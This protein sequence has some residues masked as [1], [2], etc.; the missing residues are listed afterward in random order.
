VPSQT[1]IDL[2]SGAGGATQGLTDAGVTVLGAIENDEIAADSYSRNHPK[3]AVDTRDIRLVDEGELRAQ[4]GLAVGELTLLKACPP[5]QGFSSLASGK[6][7]S[8]RNDLV[9][10]V[11]RFVREF[12]PRSVLLENV[13]G[14]R[15]DDRLRTLLEEISALG[16]VSAQYIVQATE[17]GVPQ[18]RRRLIVMAIRGGRVED[19]PDNVMALLPEDFD[20]SAKTAG[21]ALDRLAETA[22]AGDSLDRSRKHSSN[23]IE[24]IAAVPLNGTRF[25]LPVKHQLACHTRLSERGL[26]TATASYGRVKRDSAA[27]TMTTR[28]TTPSCGSFIHPTE[29]RGLTLREAAVLQTFPVDYQFVGNYGE[30]ERQIGNA[31]PVRLAHALGTALLTLL[32]LKDLS[33][34]A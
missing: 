4:L 16:Y 2:F 10:D 34:A 1:A 7:D 22:I 5:C 6:V 29:N 33:E 20:R 11:S 17:F 23:I 28:C 30:I 14:L 26:R 24:R 12:M 3:T 18:R 15:H 27:P 31:V 9:L 13:P 21:D 32:A 25:D 8:A 19:F